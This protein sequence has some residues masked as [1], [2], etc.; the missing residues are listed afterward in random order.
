MA[1]LPDEQW[2]MIKDSIDKKNIARSSRYKR[3]HCG[4]GG[5]VKMP[6]DY[7]NKKERLSMNSEVRSYNMNRPMSWHD[8]KRLPKDLKIEYIK[9]LRSEFDVPN[10]EIANFMGISTSHLSKTLTNLGLGLGKEKSLD[11]KRWYGTNKATLFGIWLGGNTAEQIYSE[12]VNEGVLE[13]ISETVEEPQNNV[14]DICED[15]HEEENS[16]AE[17]CEE[18]YEAE[19]NNEYNDEERNIEPMN[20]NKERTDIYSYYHKPVAVPDSGEMEFD[21]NAD[22]ALE[23]LKLVLGNKKVN[24][25]VSWYVRKD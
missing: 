6:S 10:L 9:K 24:L 14:I 8:F 17:I 25:R 5:Y 13:P 16:A 12:E 7:M 22:D 11:S 2:M 1:R 18:S 4:K 23:M 20:E 21:C 3:S 15:V 19:E